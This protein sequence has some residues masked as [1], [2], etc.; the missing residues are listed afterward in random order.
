VETLTYKLSFSN[1]VSDID[2]V[3]FHDDEGGFFERLQNSEFKDRQTVKNG[4][5]P[6]PQYSLTRKALKLFKSRQSFK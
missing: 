1:F 3:D 6:L 5:S 2:E 4:P